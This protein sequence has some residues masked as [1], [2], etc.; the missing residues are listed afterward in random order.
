MGLYHS[1]SV[2]VV[3]DK[4]GDLVFSLSKRVET[5]LP[6]QVEAKAINWAAS[7]AVE[8]G[9]KNLVVKND[10]KACIEALKLLLIQV[11]GESQSHLPTLFSR[12]LMANTLFLGRVGESQTK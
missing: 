10:T 8:R 1:F 6:L 5:N 4:R 11:L 7:L 12:H 9:S 2:I 3:R